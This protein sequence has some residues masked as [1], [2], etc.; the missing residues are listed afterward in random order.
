MGEERWSKFLYTVTL[1]STI[2]VVVGFIGTYI[3]GNPTLYKLG[4]I[5][6]PIMILSFLVY[7]KKVGVLLI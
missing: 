6:L 1:L 2:T 3:I 7:K 5:F 4:Y